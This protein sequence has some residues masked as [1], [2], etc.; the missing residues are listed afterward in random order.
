MAQSRQPNRFALLVGVDQYLNNDAR[1]DKQGSILSLSNLQ[2]CVNDVAAIRELLQTD[3]Q[4]DTPSILTSSPSPAALWNTADAEPIESPDRLPTFENIKKEFD[5]V[6]NQAKAG[7]F[8]F[9]HFSGHGAR[10]DPAQESPP[11]RLADPSLLTVDFCQGRPAV[12]GW[13]LNQWLR[14]LN[15]KGVHV[16]ALL[17]SCYSGGAWR[18]GRFRTPANWPT[19]P[20]LPIDEA[21]ARDVMFEPGN[22][23]GELEP[24]WSINPKDFT[25]MAACESRQKAAEQT[26]NGKSSGAFTHALIKHL[27][28]NKRSG[29]QSTYRII[30]DQ[31]ALDVTG[32]SPVVYG[33]DRLLFFDKVE[34]FSATPLVAK[35]GNGTVSLPVGKSHGICLG[36]EFCAFLPS[37]GTGFSIM[38]VNDFDCTAR[39]SGETER[40]LRNHQ[41]LVV[42]SR[43]SFCEKTLTVLVD[44]GFE[45]EFKTSLSKS[46]Q[47]R[48][49]SLVEITEMDETSES[50]DTPL[51][52]VQ[53][54][55]HIEIFGP[56][57]WI[58]YRE[59]VHGLAITG[60]DLYER[61]SKTAVV[62]SHLARFEQVLNLKSLASD[63]PPPFE[64]G[65]T[66]NGS[67]YPGPFPNN[68]THAFTFQNTCQNDLYLTVAF[69][70]PGFNIKQLYPSSDSGECVLGGTS[71]SF[72]FHISIPH[73]L[74]SAR[75]VDPTRRHRD[76]VRTI[77]TR[78]KNVSWRSLELPHIWN[79]DQVE[80]GRVSRSI[81]RDARIVSETFSWWVRDQEIFTH[82][83]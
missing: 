50:D 54:G 16:V 59:P 40:A 20:N 41:N 31:I 52:V 7:D 26:I 14:S 67:V 32:Q 1:K 75:S 46:L 15:E 57:L 63:E 4:V 51:R 83:T 25:L 73:E 66:S 3:F 56:E 82:C 45:N 34:P 70:G 37:A 30:R 79:V 71:K 68:Q 80:I 23:D 12:R 78:G 65:L 38:Q 60:Q 42:P 69:L 18:S 10:L 47:N 9:F 55:G 21:A 61:A 27:K 35:I 81:G 43:W 44:P 19:I 36:S 64:V 6:T 76:I 28:Q 5:N 8:F 2:G 39:I 13:Q 17:D 24:S 72:S 58:G 33:R 49:A 53:T 22:R 62:L 29:K 77:V 48:I 11:D 74:R